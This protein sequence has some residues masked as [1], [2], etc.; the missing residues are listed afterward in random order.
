MASQQNP[1][2]ALIKVQSF[3]ELTLTLTGSTGPTCSTPSAASTAIVWR[4]LPFDVRTRRPKEAELARLT[5]PHERL[6]RQRS[7][8]AHGY[9]RRRIC[10]GAVRGRRAVP[11][12][13]QDSRQPCPAEISVQNGP[14]QRR[15]SGRNAGKAASS[16]SKSQ[17]V[18][19][20]EGGQAVATFD[21]PSGNRQREH[22][23]GR[24]TKHSYRLSL[25]GYRKICRRGAVCD[26][27]GQLILP[28]K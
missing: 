21:H 6:T 27:R 24:N 4:L 5:R 8:R 16:P 22:A 17:L 11:L 14:T 13:A 7:W 18:G 1:H 10:C 2:A 25:E 26:R 12:N 15:W 23:F 20:D 28:S 19:G 9:I 3:A